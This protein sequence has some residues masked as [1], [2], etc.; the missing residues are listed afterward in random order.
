MEKEGKE[1]GHP[2]SHF[3]QRHWYIWIF[4]NLFFLHTSVLMFYLSTSWLV[5]PSSIFQ[6]IGLPF[7]GFQMANLGLGLLLCWLHRVSV[8]TCQFYFL[9]NSVKHWPILIIFGTQHHKV[10]DYSLAHLTLILLL[11]YLVKFRSRSLAVYSNEFILGSAC[12]GLK[13]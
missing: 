5:S 12:V 3:R 10:N 4:S 9:N 8:K 2:I 11:H 6:P 13:N 7:R 1:R